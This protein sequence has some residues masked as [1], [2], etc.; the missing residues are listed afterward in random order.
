MVELETKKGC[1][2]SERD[3][4]GYFQ[5]DPRSVLIAVFMATTTSW[6]NL[7]CICGDQNRYFKPKCDLF[8][9]LTRCFEM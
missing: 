4:T 3:T 5:E 6:N 2:A 9:T 7:S 1:Q 8:L